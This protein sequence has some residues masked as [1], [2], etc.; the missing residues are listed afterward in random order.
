MAD[1]LMALPSRMSSSIWESELMTKSALKVPSLSRMPMPTSA[2]LR[3][4]RSLAPSP[5]MHTFLL[6]LPNSLLSLLLLSY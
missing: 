3:A 4:M 5:T 1:L 6:K 2:Y